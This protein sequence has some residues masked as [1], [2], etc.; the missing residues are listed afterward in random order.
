M[1]DKEYRDYINDIIESVN[2]IKEFTDAID[3]EEFKNDIK[4]RFAVIRCFEIIGEAVKRIPEDFRGKYPLIPWKVMSGMR[5]RLI[6]GYDVV[7]VSVLWRTI[8]N[9][10]PELEKNIKNIKL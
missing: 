6:H 5:D 1:S 3:F 9:D 10:I 7:D 4:T 8:K 2:Y